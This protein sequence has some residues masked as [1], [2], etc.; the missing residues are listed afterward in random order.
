MYGSVPGPGLETQRQGWPC[1][2]SKGA[3]GGWG[4]REGGKHFG[5]GEGCGRAAQGVEW[6][7]D[8]LPD[9][10][11]QPWLQSGHLDLCL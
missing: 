1:M 7:Q 11:P 3:W 4:N 6:G 10:N 9:P 5:V 8:P 2:S